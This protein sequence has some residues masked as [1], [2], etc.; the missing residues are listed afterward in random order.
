M[1]YEDSGRNKATEATTLSPDDEKLRPENSAKFIDSLRCLSSKTSVI[2]TTTPSEY[3]NFLR[4]LADLK[5]GEK[6]RQEKAKADYDERVKQAEAKVDDRNTPLFINVNDM[7]QYKGEDEQRNKNVKE[8]YKYIV[9]NDIREAMWNT[10][11]DVQNGTQIYD[12]GYEDLDYET[13]TQ[14]VYDPNDLKV[15]KNVPPTR[16]SKFVTHIPTR[17]KSTLTPSVGRV[18]F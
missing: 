5:A 14:Y 18:L 15:F 16:T 1:S 8:A 3:Q 12:E 13:M 17:L 11:R 4:K 7:M 2:L 6:R 9:K 10:T